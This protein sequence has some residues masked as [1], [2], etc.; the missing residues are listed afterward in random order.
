VKRSL[1]IVVSA[2]LIPFSSALAQESAPDAVARDAELVESTVDAEEVSLVDRLSEALGRGKVLFNN[3]F[4]VEVADTRG[5][6]SSTAVTNRIRLGYETEEIYGFRGL[7]EMEN[8]SSPAT[9]NYFVPATGQGT[10]TRTVVADPTGTEV[11]QAYV[12][13]SHR[14]ADGNALFEVWGGRQ[15]ITQDDQRFIGNVGWRQFEQTFDAARIESTLGV[16]GLLLSYS[17]VWGVQRIFGPDGP[18][19]DSESHLIRASYKFDDAFELIGFGYLL[20]FEDDAPAAS[21]DTFGVRAKGK[22]NLGLGDYAEKGPKLSYDVTYAH[23]SDAGDNPVSYD[24]D[25]VA[26]ELAVS[27]SELGSA[28]VG[29]QFLG[30]DGGNAAFQFPLGTNHKFQGY[31]DVFLTTPAV[32]LQDLY[33][34]VKGDLPWGLKGGITYHQ[35]W[36]DEGGTDFGNE[37]DAVLSKKI[38]ENLSVLA[39]LAFFDGHNGQPDTTRVWVQATVSF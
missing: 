18:N 37:I 4:R 14:D 39:K 22:I 1:T 3:R 16:E 36:S 31:A 24:A 30:S 32:G 21:T 28:T 35:F 12:R 2:G 5:R 7:I 13:Y 23:Q 9:D 6:D 15:R 20:D 26:A 19:W 25:F 10:P 11:N 29:Y 34:G 27:K 33:V 38:T 8:V 17:Y